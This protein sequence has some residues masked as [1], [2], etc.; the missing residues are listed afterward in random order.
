MNFQNWLAKANDRGF[1]ALLRMT[2]RKKE[3]TERDD[4]RSPSGMTTRKAKANAKVRKGKNAEAKGKAEAKA[5][6]AYRFF[7]AS[8]S[9]RVRGQ[10]APRSRDRLRSAR[11]LPPVWH[12]A[13]EVVSLSA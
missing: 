4:S 12:W 10:S 8:S 9:S 11:T 13:Q 5:K 7:N 1:F 2:R 3:T 6:E